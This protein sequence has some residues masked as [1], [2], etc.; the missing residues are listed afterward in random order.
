MSLAEEYTLL[1]RLELFE[2]LDSAELKRLIF[3][4]DR[5]RLDDG[6]YLFRQGDRSDTVFA[7]LDGKL[8]VTIDDGSN[9]TEIA[10]REC[11][12]LVGEMA[13]VSGE[14]RSASIRAKGNA[15]VMGI[16]GPLF[17]RTMTENPAA[18][19]KVMRMLSDRLAALS[20]LVSDK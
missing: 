18:A 14:K 10:V 20:Q 2:K 12:E 6:E 17:V 3:A 5:Y 15:E 4:S 1:S 7:I 19:L 8:A 9:E 13:A 16:D 11:G